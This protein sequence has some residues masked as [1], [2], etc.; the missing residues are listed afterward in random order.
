M[1]FGL[2]LILFDIDVAANP[3]STIFRQKRIVVAFKIVSKDHLVVQVYPS[4]TPTWPSASESLRR[5]RLPR[6]SESGDMLGKRMRGKRNA[7]QRV[8]NAPFRVL[9]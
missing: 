9:P 7:S 6:P 4:L 3:R 1:A 8:L 5:R 2:Q